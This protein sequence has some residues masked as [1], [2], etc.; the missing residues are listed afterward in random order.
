MV[1]RKSRQAVCGRQ[2]KATL[3]YQLNQSLPYQEE[4]NA[5][6]K[7]V[8]GDIVVIY[9]DLKKKGPS[10]STFWLPATRPQMLEPI[11]F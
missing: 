1:F 10:G 7:K 3:I 5:I 11:R 9:R 6:P 2:I 8:H 4:M